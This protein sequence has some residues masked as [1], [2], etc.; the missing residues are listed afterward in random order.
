MHFVAVWYWWGAVWH[1]EYWWVV[2]W[3]DKILITGCISGHFDNT[4]V[5]SDKRHC[6]FNVQR[7]RCVIYLWVHHRVWHFMWRNNYIHVKLWIEIIYAC[8]IL[9]LNLGCGWVITYS[10]Y[11]MCFLSHDLISD[12]FG[13][14]YEV[15]ICS[16][17]LSASWLSVR[18]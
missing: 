1:G 7:R 13:K 4:V 3:N 16:A 14:G 12:I 17:V 18:C 5:G 11:E 6:Y 8:L 9:T 15:K 10:K 2:R